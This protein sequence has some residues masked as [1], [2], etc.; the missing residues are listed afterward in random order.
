MQIILVVNIHVTTKLNWSIIW[1]AWKYTVTM[2]IKLSTS[3]KQ[4]QNQNTKKYEIMNKILV[5]NMIIVCDMWI[6]KW[7]NMQNGKT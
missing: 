5:L 4:N 2:K 6:W 7:R 3:N 1:V